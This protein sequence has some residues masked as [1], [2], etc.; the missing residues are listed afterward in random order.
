MLPGEG[1]DVGSRKH[2]APPPGTALGVV[3]VAL[4]TAVVILALLLY[5]A[6]ASGGTLRASD[7]AGS[8][9]LEVSTPVLPD[10]DQRVLAEPA[11]AGVNGAEVR[12]WTASAPV[13]VVP[14]GGSA[15]NLP[16]DLRVSAV[17][18]PGSDG[19]ASRA[20]GPDDGGYLGAVV[21]AA[22]ADRF[23][24][25][26]GDTLAVA[27]GSGTLRVRVLA[28]ELSSAEESLLRTVRVEGVLVLGVSPA[29]VALFSD[30]AVL[31]WQFL[32]DEDASVTGL[33]EAAAGGVGVRRCP[34]G[35][36]RRTRRHDGDG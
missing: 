29:D 18:W 11:V 20:V 15:V 28:K 4:L 36:G 3:L 23:G 33:R 32:A 35:N 25:S 1:P 22:D 9:S 7:R 2:D 13:D 26:D 5:P 34:R 8:A 10:V 17:G 31:G 21:T 16:A 12:E 19:V 24:L 6:V 14:S 30:D 27:T